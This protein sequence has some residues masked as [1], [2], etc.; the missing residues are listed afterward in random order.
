MEKVI[1]CVCGFVVNGETDEELVAAAQKHIDSDHP[2]LVG[3]SPS[4]IC[5]R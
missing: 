1:R 2:E 3:R 5:S 4:Q